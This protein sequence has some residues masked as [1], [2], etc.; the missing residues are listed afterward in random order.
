M[1]EGRPSNANE[2]KDRKGLSAK[3]SLK[4]LSSLSDSGAYMQ[5]KESL[6]YYRVAGWN[7]MDLL[8]YAFNSLT[9]EVGKLALTFGRG[10]PLRELIMELD[11]HFGITA[12][13]DTLRREFY[14][15]TQGTHETVSQFAGRVGYQLMEFQTT[16]PGAIPQC[17]EE[18]IKKG[19]LYAGLKPHLKS[20]M[21]F[22][23]EMANKGR[24]LTYCQLLKIAQHTKTDY[25][26]KEP[27]RHQEDMG[28]IHH[29]SSKPRKDFGSKL[30]IRKVQVTLQES[31]ESEESHDKQ[32]PQ[33]EEESEEETYE[34]RIFKAGLSFKKEHGHCFE[35]GKAGHFPKDC[36]ERKEKAAKKN[37]NNKG[38]LKKGDQKPQDKAAGEKR[39]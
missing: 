20:A 29:S 34:T 7:D 30:A 6:N 37:S 2:K 14:S 10:L 5:W 24:D 32:H 38:V 13:L 25:E 36:P 3:P 35:C 11:E 1:T 9:G 4:N 15:M 21:T 28:K 16:F 39:E 8:P 31:S 27:S 23:R 22:C 33:A 19:R 12:G 18:E 17:D 26:D